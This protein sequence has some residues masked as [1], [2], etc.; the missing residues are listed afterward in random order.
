MSDLKAEISLALTELEGL[1]ETYG[2]DREV[3]LDRYVETLARYGRAGLEAVTRWPERSEEWPALR[4]LVDLAEKIERQTRASAIANAGGNGGTPV[5]N[6][7]GAVTRSER[8]GPGYVR[9]WLDG[10][11][12]PILGAEVIRTTKHGVET[13]SRDFGEL[14][15]ALGV[16]LSH[17]R[18]AEERLTLYVEELREAGR[19]EGERRRARA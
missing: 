9:S 1:V 15:A 18:A 8:G 4:A 17:D 13:I 16:K 12:Y 6:F 11:T 10:S 7:I 2:R 3:A 5:S 19:L 14:A